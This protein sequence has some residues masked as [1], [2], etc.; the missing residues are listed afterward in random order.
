MFATHLAPPLQPSLV[1]HFFGRLI[2]RTPPARA[3]AAPATT[4]AMPAAPEPL[5]DEL[6]DL[7]QRVR[8]LGEW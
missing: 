6:P 4:S 5:E 8:E 1:S 7:A 2:A 3:V